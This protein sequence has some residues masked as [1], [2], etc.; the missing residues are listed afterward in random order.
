MGSP[1][2]TTGRRHSV[3]VNT[4]RPAVF[5]RLFLLFVLVPMVDLALLF[6]VGGRIGLAPTVGIVIATALLGSWL[7]RREGA[8][9]W[10]KVQRKMATGGIPGPEL[11]DGLVILVSGTLLLTPGFLTDIVG[12]LGLFPPSRAIVRKVLKARFES[13]VLTG[14]ARVVH[15]GTFGGPTGGFQASFGASPFAPPAQPRIED[16]EVIDDGTERP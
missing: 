7:A 11:I 14:K 10:S 9:A 1:R 15:S 4:P 12:L 2:G 3:L 16:A 13:A 8:A 5:G 6:S